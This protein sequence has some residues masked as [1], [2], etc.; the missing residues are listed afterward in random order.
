MLN[1]TFAEALELGR[2][3][4]PQALDIDRRRELLSDSRS[5]LYG[6]VRDAE[7]IVGPSSA[8]GFPNQADLEHLPNLRVLA[9]AASGYEQFDLS[10][11][12]RRGVRVVNARTR[13]S[14]LSVAEHAIAMTLAVLRRWPLQLSAQERGESHRQVG[15]LL[16]GLRVG[17]VGY[18]SIGRQTARLFQALGGSV[19]VVTR[20]GPSAEV[21]DGLEVVSDI[22]RA[23]PLLD[24]VSLHLR[25]EPTT[26]N[27]LNRH[28]LGLLPHGAIVVNTARREL[29]EESALAEMLQS[30]ALGGAA[31]DDVPAQPELVHATNC[32]I[33]N[34]LGNRSSDGMIDVV[35][36]ILDDL[37]AIATGSQPL[38]EVTPEGF[39]R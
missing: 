35:R 32:L 21:E 18:G 16:A 4:T 26:R 36:V 38:N 37:A 9:V 39:V 28:R 14:A 11:L 29:I 20:R 17:V 30:G 31:L 19:T 27:V 7:A 33:F 6:E 10:A 25:L 22:D 8:I 34:H 23:L 15:R 2:V 24:V 5:V 12:A 13:L 3:S 1:P